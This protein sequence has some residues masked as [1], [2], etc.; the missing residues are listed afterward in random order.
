[1]ENTKLSTG[2]KFLYFVVMLLS[3]GFAILSSALVFK[4][5]F[6]G[7]IDWFSLLGAIFFALSFGFASFLFGYKVFM[8]VARH[9]WIK[10]KL[11]GA[12]IL[13]IFLLAYIV[14]APGFFQYRARAYDSDAKSN[15]HYMFV[16]CQAYWLENGDDQNCDLNIVSQEEYGFVLNDKVSIDG[17]G[18]A[19]DFTATAHHEAGS[20]IFTINNQGEVTESWRPKS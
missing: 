4:S 15:L 19:E 10:G 9:G 12:V 2:Q 7:R 18:M 8:P 14:G 13:S 3:F 11:K 1:M 20:H 16:A 17:K 5:L 6:S